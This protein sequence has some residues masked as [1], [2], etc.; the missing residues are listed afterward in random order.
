MGFRRSEA[1]VSQACI[2][3]NNRS[4]NIQRRFPISLD[5]QANKNTQ[6]KNKTKEC[7]GAAG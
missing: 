1:S 6:N 3:N 4:H 5:I 7:Q 2:N